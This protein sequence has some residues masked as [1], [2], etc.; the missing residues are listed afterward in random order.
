VDTSV[1]IA[2]VSAFK[3]SFV[4]RE[5]PSADA[6]WEWVENGSFVWLVTPDILQEYRRVAK[7]LKVRPH[8]AAGS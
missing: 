2:G 3:G 4:R 1:V 5:N 7:R 6:L 8:V